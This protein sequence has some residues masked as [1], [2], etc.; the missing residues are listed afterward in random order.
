ML[1]NRVGVTKVGQ[2]EG[3]DRAKDN[4]EDEDKGKDQ[5]KDGEVPSIYSSKINK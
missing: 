3:R 5:G 2:N 4:D 1:E